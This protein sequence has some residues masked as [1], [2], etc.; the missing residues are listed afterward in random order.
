MVEFEFEEKIYAV[1]IWKEVII[2]AGCV[3]F[4][5]PIPIP[6]VI[7]VW[8]LTFMFSAL[9]TPQILELSGIGSKEVLQGLDIPVKVDLPVG[10]NAQEHYF[11]GVTYG[12][13]FAC[14]T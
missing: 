6:P 7:N 8:L 14:L 9:K 10:K 4:L 5:I 3:F 1:K 13:F 12:E 11:M 2:C